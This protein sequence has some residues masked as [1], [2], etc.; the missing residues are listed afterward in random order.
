MDLKYYY[1]SNLWTKRNWMAESIV[2]N[3]REQVAASS[4][5]LLFWSFSKL[6][7]GWESPGLDVLI[8]IPVA[9]KLSHKVYSVSVQCECAVWVCMRAC[10]CV[11]VCV[12]ACVG[13]FVLCV[14]C[15]CKW[16][17]FIENSKHPY[18][19]LLIRQ[20]IYQNPEFTTSHMVVVWFVAHFVCMLSFLL[21]MSLLH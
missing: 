19:P 10:V 11:L 13:I 17:I 14:I 3:A 6:G 15:H 21:R 9:N 7:K 1:H 18:I 16:Y 2:I 20:V 8:H 12:R 4:F 5:L